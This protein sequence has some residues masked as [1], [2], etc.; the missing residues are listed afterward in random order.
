M[1]ASL[2]SIQNFSVTQCNLFLGALGYFA[3]SQCFGSEAATFLVTETGFGVLCAAYT[4]VNLA[5]YHHN[6]FCLFREWM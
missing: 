1:K 2:W 4:I 6:C 5:V 3:Q